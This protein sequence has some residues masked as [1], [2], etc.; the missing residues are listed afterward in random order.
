MDRKR[1]AGVGRGPWVP[2]P[3][4]GAHSGGG[5]GNGPEQWTEDPA[6]PGETADRAKRKRVRGGI[7]AGGGEGTGAAPEV[8]TPRPPPGPV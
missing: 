8:G 6:G 5:V 7:G 1:S 3:E 4:L 2:N